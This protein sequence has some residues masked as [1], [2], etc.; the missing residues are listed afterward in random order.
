MERQAPGLKKEQVMS[1]AGDPK[2]T[3]VGEG[4]TTQ[5]LG[6]GLPLTE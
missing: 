6:M 4:K 1:V 5:K 2:E 3:I